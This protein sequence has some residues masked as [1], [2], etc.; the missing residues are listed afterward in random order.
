MNITFSHITNLKRMWQLSK[1]NLNYEKSKQNYR[2][3][4]KKITQNK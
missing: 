1:N 4:I 2:E 3:Q